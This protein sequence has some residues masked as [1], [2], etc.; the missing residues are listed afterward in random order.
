M[1][2]ISIVGTLPIFLLVV[3]PV[4]AA[5]YLTVVLSRRTQ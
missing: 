4:A 3:G 1:L 2:A 5:V